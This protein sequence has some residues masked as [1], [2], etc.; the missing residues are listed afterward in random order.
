MSTMNDTLAAIARKQHGVFSRKQA[1]DSGMTKSAIRVAVRRNLWQVVMPR[2]YAVRGAPVTHLSRAWAVRLTIKGVIAF[3][4]RTA[5]LLAGAP[6]IDPAAPVEVAILNKRRER[7]LVNV[8]VRRVT[9]KWMA[10]EL[11]ETDLPTLRPAAAVFDYA[12]TATEPE[13]RRLVE[14]LLREGRVTLDELRSLRSR[15]RPGSALVGEVIAVLSDGNDYWVRRAAALFR[16]SGLP[17]LKC[18]LHVRTS[19][20]SSYLDIY[21]EDHSRAVEI[22]DYESHSRSRRFRK[23][24]RRHNAAQDEL[25]ILFNYFTPVDIRDCPDEVVATM[26][27]ALGPTAAAA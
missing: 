11:S 6:G 20:G 21:F 15:G 19:L 3:T 13:V 1:L 5:L 18:H 22:D 17:P 27:A 16:K 9:A 10:Q 8:I 26:R 2:V 25:K 24:R 4:G 7:R 23:D 12:A 14:W